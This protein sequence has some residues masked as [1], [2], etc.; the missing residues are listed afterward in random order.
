[1]QRVW[2]RAHDSN[3]YVTIREQGKQRQIKLLKAPNTKDGKRLA[4]QKL[5]EELTA[6]SF[7]PDPVIRHEPWLT[8]SQVIQGFLQHSIINHEEGTAT[9]HRQIL[10]P[11]DEL[12]GDLRITQLKKQHVT[13]W[14]TKRGFNETSQSL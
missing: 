14:L 2:F 6:R 5:I 12:F 11:F 1:M 13:A 9:W 3:W 8:V 7:Q 10:T 4:E